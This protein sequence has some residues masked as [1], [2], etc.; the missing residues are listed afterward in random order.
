MFTPAP[1]AT[2]S[3]RR[4]AH[5]R[6]DPQGTPVHVWEQSTVSRA[7][8]RVCGASAEPSSRGGPSRDYNSQAPPRVHRRRVLPTV[9]MCFIRGCGLPP[10]SGTRPPFPPRDVL[11]APPCQGWC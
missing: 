6:E 4:D 3:G 10:R 1:Q 8:S 11:P 7:L 2:C 9:H 5:P